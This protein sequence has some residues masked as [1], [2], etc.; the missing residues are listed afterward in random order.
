MAGSRSSKTLTLLAAALAAST[1]FAAPPEPVAIYGT[2]L[3]GE[4]NKIY[5]IL[6][7]SG[8]KSELF[9]TLPSDPSTDNQSPNGIAVDQPRGLIYYSVDEDANTSTPDKL[10]AISLETP[11]GTQAS[12]VL[13]GELESV[14]NGAAMYEGDYFYLNNGTNEWRRVVLGLNDD[15]EVVV[16]DEAPY[17]TGGDPRGYGLG[18]VAGLQGVMY[19]SVRQKQFTGTGSDTEFKFVKVDLSSGTGGVCS[20]T[21]FPQTI[22]RQ[23]Q[24]AW[25][26]DYKLYGYDPEDK[27]LYVIDKDTGARSAGPDYAPGSAGLGLVG[28]SDIDSLPP[29]ARVAITKKTN[30][31][32]NNDA[33]STGPEITVGDEVTWTYEIAN[34]G[35]L[36]LTDVTVTDD[37][38]ADDQNA[39]TCDADLDGSLAGESGNV[40]QTLGVGESTFCEATGTAVLGPYSNIGTVTADYTSQFDPVGDTVT[41]SDSDKYVGVEE[42]ESHDVALLVL[43]RDSIY[44]SS[45]CYKYKYGRCYKFRKDDPDDEDGDDDDDRK[46]PKSKKGQTLGSLKSWNSSELGSSDFGKRSVLPYFNNPSNFGTT[47][48]LATGSVY[49]HSKYG[50][51]EGWLAP[52]CIPQK[53]LSGAAENDN[54]CMTGGDREQGIN[55]FLFNGFT[56]Y[57][58]AP[59]STSIPGRRL[60]TVA[61]VLPLRAR[62]LKLLEGTKVCAVVYDGDIEVSYKDKHGKKYDYES[63][64]KDDKGSKYGQEFCAADNNVPG[65]HK[66]KKDDAPCIRGDLAGKTFGIVAFEVIEARDRDCKYCLPDVDVKVLDPAQT[67]NNMLLYNAPVPNGP[68]YPKDIAVDPLYDQVGYKKYRSLYYEP[69]LDLLF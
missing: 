51:S 57:A 40:I 29:E 1:V 32:D 65:S 42:E 43:D 31:T 67:C 3:N 46:A 60:Q 17:C 66:S 48:T 7:N 69:S 38:I 15:D 26:V 10:Y 16:Q 41:D 54:T 34:A 36:E 58:G 47:V 53:W 56:S 6:L 19:A 23:M 59:S 68:K 52:D 44:D 24:L 37:E 9:A 55:N 35:Q 62:G 22:P 49:K 50:S 18:D 27:L 8:N 14:A 4:G 20:Y 61:Q 33:E 13:I 5:R 28:M 12:P 21:E 64:D 30:G 25:G 11:V 2:G 39:I 63:R 45:R